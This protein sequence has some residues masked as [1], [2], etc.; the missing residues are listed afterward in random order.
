[1][2]AQSTWALILALS[3]FIKWRLF[4]AAPSSEICPVFPLSSVLCSSITSHLWCATDVWGCTNRISE[5]RGLYDMLSRTLCRSADADGLQR[6]YRGAGG[7]SGVAAS[8]G[9]II[10]YSCSGE[11]E[12]KTQTVTFNYAG[13]ANSPKS[14]V[15]SMSVNLIIFVGK[16]FRSS[17]VRF[18]SARNS[19]LKVFFLFFFCSASSLVRRSVS[20]FLS[21]FF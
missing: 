2:C 14:R 6:W 10:W 1:M 18:V 9:H 19:R 4:K 12:W 11:N 8:R 13:A 21:F 16:T 15:F 7:L 5:L 20:F 3:T 17:F